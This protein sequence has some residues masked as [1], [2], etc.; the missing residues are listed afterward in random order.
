VFSCFTALVVYR[1]AHILIR[2]RLI[3]IDLAFVVLSTAQSGLGSA[4]SIYATLDGVEAGVQVM[5]E[6]DGSQVFRAFTK[7]SLLP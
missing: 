3:K 4:V 5:L 6:P 2:G 1:E 7:V